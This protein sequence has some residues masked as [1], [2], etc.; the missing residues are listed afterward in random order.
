MPGVTII[1]FD[2]IIIGSG[3]AGLYAAQ[4][5]RQYGSVLILTKGP[6]SQ[7]NTR[8]AQGG[9]AAAV[10]A[11]DSPNLHWE[12]TMKA[13]AGLCDP[14]AVMAMALEGPACVR[15]LM[16][17][18]VNFDTLHGEINLAQ[19][20]AHS[21]PRVLHARGDA[22]G[23]EIEGALTR[24]TRRTAVTIRENHRANRLLVDGGRCVG[25]EALNERDGKLHA[26]RSRN[27]ILCSGGAGRLFAYTT[28][29]S[30]ATGDGVALAFRAGAGIAD[31]EFFQFHPTALRMAAAPSFLISEAVR[32]AGAHLRN[33]EGKRFMSRYHELAELA[34]RDIVARAAVQ[35]MSQS[36]SD[37]V[38]LDLRHLD[39]AE[40]RTHFPTIYSRCQHYGIDITKDPIP[41]APAAHYMTGGVLTDLCGR[42]SVP[43]L[44]ACGEV[45]CSG[46][47]GANRLASNSLLEALV[48]ARR[49]VLDSQGEHLPAY[50]T[51]EAREPAL[52]PIERIFVPLPAAAA[53]RK[54]AG[55]TLP[56]LRQLMWHN[57]GIVRD[58]DGLLRA[59]E[60]VLDWLARAPAGTT[61]RQHEYRTS[62]VLGLLLTTGARIREE[63]RGA[64]YRVDHPE[65]DDS[66]RHR[67]VI[68]RE[69]GDRS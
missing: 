18:G 21:V 51:P 69:D 41:V 45:A 48:F 47:H 19:E 4:Y 34:P 29:P 14:Q 52:A 28:N 17:L 22:T 39:A 53:G 33:G 38:F 54:R 58:R 40:T 62:L 16:T 57:T 68:F 27:V 13:G 1:T 67:I 65:P 35:E 30:I 37:C 26:F 59:E 36:G 55:G 9:V 10:A 15:E 60:Q 64:H 3:I 25:V 63:S 8:Y 5:A 50:Q 56:A 42:T 66:W 12:D 61:R 49:I 44:Y 6:L 11:N 24:H 31:M 20:G 2:Y 7:S 46:V 32:G 43:G 23:A